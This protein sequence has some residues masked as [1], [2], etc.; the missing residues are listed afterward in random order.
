MAA[1]FKRDGEHIYASASVSSANLPL[2]VAKRNPKRRFSDKTNEQMVTEFMM[3]SKF[4]CEGEKELV[5]IINKCLNTRS[6]I[7]DLS[8]VSGLELT[9]E[10]ISQ[11]ILPIL[12]DNLHITGINLGGTEIDD[13][14]I[15]TLANNCELEEIICY[16]TNINSEGVIALARNK[17]IRKLDISMT[18]FALGSDSKTKKAVE[19]LSNS[20]IEWLDISGEYV[21][22][23][24]IDEAAATAL[25]S[26]ENL[27]YLNI[28]GQKV[29]FTKQ[30]EL[31]MIRNNLYKA[32]KKEFLMG[33]HEGIGVNSSILMFSKMG[34][35]SCEDLSKEI[36]KYI[37][38]KFLN[39]TM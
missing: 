23:A 15:V 19:E 3:A 12:N 25:I 13:K 6:K 4:T 8:D 30:I 31:L 26:N 28:S 32:Q 20:L 36:F 16:H 1:T 34:G 11:S 5:E 35:A 14:V 17:Y 10:N 9:V 29:V 7:L 21:G 38:P 33:T 24:P 39:L 27:T 2:S 18:S 22:E 37:E